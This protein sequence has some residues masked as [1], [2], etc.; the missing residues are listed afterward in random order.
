MRCLLGA[1]VVI[2]CRKAEPGSGGDCGRPV[3]DTEF[4]VG[5]LEMAAHGSLA[6]VQILSKI[7]DG[8]TGSNRAKQGRLGIVEV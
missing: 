7:D 1:S 4:D 5:V 6:V 8:P 2:A 3:L